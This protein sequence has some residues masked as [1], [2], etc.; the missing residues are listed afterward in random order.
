MHATND[1]DALVR[2]FDDCGGTE[3]Q[4]L[5]H[6]YSRFATTL[7]E[8]V[9]SSPPR[10]GTRVLD[11]GAHWLHQAALFQ[12]AG[13]AVTAV[14]LPV[15]FEFPCVR[16]AAR[17]LDI[18]LCAVKDLSRPDELN[19]LPEGGFDLVLFC[20]IIEHITFNPVAFWTQIHRL[21]RPG[22][23]IVVT[24]PNYYSTLFRPRTLRR[25]LQGMGGGV[26]VDEILGRHTYAHHWK[27]FSGAELEHYFSSLSSDFRVARR[28][29]IGYQMPDAAANSWKQAARRALP[30]LDP[31]RYANI[32]MEIELVDKRAGIQI[33]PGW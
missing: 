11:V 9:R 12:R 20:E 30:L 16:E 31:R 8:V 22:G 5:K 13:Y 25:F 14:D 1:Y 21:L 15:T 24:T 10:S 4:Y 33:Q 28:R 26:P 19:S 2:F 18:A 23:R 6:H 7:N 32:H 17:K 29:Y 27:E 3:V